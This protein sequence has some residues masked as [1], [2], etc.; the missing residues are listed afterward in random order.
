MGEYWIEP[1]P[2]VAPPIAPQESGTVAVALDRDGRL[3]E[4]VACRHCDYNLRGLALSGRCPECEMAIEQTLHGFL[5][6]FSDPAWLKRLR[7]G[8]MLLIVAILIGIV[9]AIAWI[10]VFV[11]WPSMFDASPIVAGAMV[12]IPTAGLT[13]LSIVGYVLVTAPEPGSTSNGAGL[14]ARRL[15]RIGLISSAVI[16][17]IEVISDPETYAPLVVLFVE[18]EWFSGLTWILG[19]LGASIGFVGLFALFIYGRRLASRLPADSLA[20]STGIVMWG[21]MLPTIG[22]GILGRAVDAYINSSYSSTSWGTIDVAIM[23]L[24]FVFGIPVLVFGIWA[25]VLMFMYRHRLKRAL[26][27]AEAGSK[28]QDSTD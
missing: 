5:L 24:Q 3:A 18:V 25:I 28:E 9:L 22:Y 6:R 14:S 2:I 23:V 4:D 15:A 20:K 27:L 16:G 13:I 11:S 10:V 7:S 8:L 21:Y 26:A 17:L 1:P 12:L 19:T